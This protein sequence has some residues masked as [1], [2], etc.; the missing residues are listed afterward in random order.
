[1]QSIVVSY[2]LYNIRLAKS[3][4]LNKLELILVYLKVIKQDLLQIQK[5]V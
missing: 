2:T 1:M 5:P 4:F 3:I